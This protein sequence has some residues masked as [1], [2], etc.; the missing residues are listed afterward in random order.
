M[1]K[2]ISVFLLVLS[3]KTGDF[4]PSLFKKIRVLSIYITILMKILTFWLSWLRMTSIL[5]V[6]FYKEGV[7]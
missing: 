2:S 3:N 5:W 4:C 7:H 1:Q 6:L